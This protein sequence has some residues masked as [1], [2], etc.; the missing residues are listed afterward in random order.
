MITTTAVGDR[1]A[2]SL[3]FSL[4]DVVSVTVAPL[5]KAILSRVGKEIGGVAAKG[6][7]AMVLGDAEQKA[8]ERAL[9]RAFTEVGRVHG[10]QLANFD[11]NAG[12]W[13]HEGATE[14]S[15]VLVAGLTPSPARLA[16]RAVDSLGPS[17]SDDERLDRILVLRPVFAAVLA[18]LAREVRAESALHT[19]LERADAART[20]E[21][22]SSIAEAMGTA[23]PSEDDRVRYL[24]WLIDQH[25][26]V[27][28][29]GVVR[30]TTVQL[31]LEEVFVGLRRDRIGTPVI[32]PGRGS[33]RNAR[34]PRRCWMP[35]SLTRPGTRL[36]WID[37]RLSTAASSPSTVMAH[38]TNPCRCWMQ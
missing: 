20:A 24:G 25:R 17:R 16:E 33:S 19:L 21:A 6:A 5:A 8:L 18:A 7:R 28:T 22:A 4:V 38:P 10:R 11:I 13:E 27:R 29:A 36:H 15:K 12:F 35:G 9:S 14:L 2:D 31:P 37:C 32:A 34:R 3:Y 26:Y 30:N 1:G 23:A